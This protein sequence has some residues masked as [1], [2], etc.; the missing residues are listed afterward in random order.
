MSPVRTKVRDRQ[1]KKDKNKNKTNVLVAKSLLKKKIKT[2]YDD[3]LSTVC[4]DVLLEENVDDSILELKKVFNAVKGGV[5]LCASQIGIFK[6]IILVS[7]SKKTEID[8]MINPEIIAHSAKRVSD[9]EGCLSYPGFYYYINR[10][11]E[12]T[13]K[14]L[15]V[16]KEE[17]TKDFKGFSS[18]IVQ[19]EIDH[20]L[21]RCKV[22]DLWRQQIE[23][24]KAKLIKSR[25]LKKM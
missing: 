21:G 17:K 11:Y 4:N 12:V 2:F 15:D 10:W 19:H 7:D 1:R 3:A 14:Y 9:S 8:I 20:T 6:K 5:G 25:K 18:R 22:G 13:V 16:N 24:E 23:V